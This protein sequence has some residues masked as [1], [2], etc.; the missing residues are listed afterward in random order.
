MTPPIDDRQEKAV[1]EALKSLTD[2]FP[3]LTPRQIIEG[4]LA[5]KALGDLPPWSTLETHRLTDVMLANRGAFVLCHFKDSTGET[6]L[7]MGAR[8]AKPGS[9]DT[10]YN[11]SGGGYA[12]QT[13]G[14][15]PPETAAREIREEIR[16]DKNVPVLDIDPVRMTLISGGV[17]NRGL[18]KGGHPTDWYGYS[19][20]LTPEEVS[21]IT[22]HCNR[23]SADPAYSTACKE[24]SGGET[25]FVRIVSLK[26]A[27]KIPTSSFAHPHEKTVIEGLAKNVG[28]S[29]PAS[30]PANPAR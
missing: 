5:R 22:A 6:Q 28:L 7:V 13:A 19:V 24:A 21:K 16:D 10:L 20:E 3:G 9:D 11:A 17:D 23:L 12:D 29:K 26:E 4:P 8:P 30:R 2:A 27:A 25:A 1:I 18:S 15:Q 14:E